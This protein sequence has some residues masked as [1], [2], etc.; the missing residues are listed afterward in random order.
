MR[1][2][3]SI[4]ALNKQGVIGAKNALPWR[5][6]T[7]MTFFK[8]QTL[9]NVVIMGRKTFDSLGRKPLPNRFNVV[10]SH[11]FRMF[12]SSSD[13][14]AATG[15]GEALAAAEAA[16]K[17]YKEIYVVGG[18]TMYEQFSQLVDRYLMTI[19]DKDVPLGDTFFD[20]GLLGEAGQ[21][22]QS[23]LLS[24]EALEGQDEASF[25]ILQ[26]IRSRSSARKSAREAMVEG[27]AKKRATIRP[28]RA[29]PLEAAIGALI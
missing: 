18:Q 19:V 1:R 27:V 12:P 23:T 29:A 24:G 9:D 25:D 6:K 2:L 28:A 4:V 7:D 26:L 22:K 15:I 14:V 16:P 17:R 5:L 8:Q 3:T 13:C 20:E 21:W 10:V 11:E